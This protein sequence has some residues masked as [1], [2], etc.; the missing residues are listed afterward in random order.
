MIHGLKVGLGLLLR[1][2]T[3]KQQ[4]NIFTL[5]SESLTRRM[6]SMVIYYLGL[7]LGVFG[8]ENS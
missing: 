3:H 8:Y 6:G 7:K 1:N 2:S 5:L 4:G